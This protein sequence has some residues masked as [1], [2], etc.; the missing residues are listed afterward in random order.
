MSKLVKIALV[1]VML[2]A[3]TSFAQSEGI[4]K[5]NIVFHIFSIA[6]PMDWGGT[7]EQSSNLKYE[8]IFTRDRD[9]KM[10]M[11]M[12]LQLKWMRDLVYQ[13]GLSFEVGAGIG[14]INFPVNE[15]KKYSYFDPYDHMNQIDSR[16]D[17]N[18]KVGL[19]YAPFVNDFILAVHAI[20]GGD[21]KY[22]GKSYQMEDFTEEYSTLLFNFVGGGDIVLGYRI[23]EKLGINA[24][25]DVTVNLFGFG[26]RTKE[27]NY[28]NDNFETI[29]YKLNHVFS[30]FQIVPCVG[31]SLKF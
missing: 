17:L 18:A 3:L 23:T 6:L 11:T 15:S 1:A 13:S 14:F 9:L 22:L 21:M 20:L 2:L 26:N 24:G 27:F 7:W 10:D 4:Q 30:G 28:R 5:K 19:G 31:V 12:G 29:D 25:V 8:N 16:F